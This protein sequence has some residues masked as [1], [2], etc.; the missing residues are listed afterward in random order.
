MNSAVKRMTRP[1]GLCLACILCSPLQAAPNF[2]YSQLHL[3]YGFAHFHKAL[4]VSHASGTDSYRHLKVWGI[5]GAYQLKNGVILGA[6]R[7]QGFHSSTL[8]QIQSRTDG[9]SV[10]Y[11]V[12]L[13]RRMDIYGNIGLYESFAKA[14]NQT[15]CVSNQDQTLG[16]DFG[17]RMGAGHWLEYGINLK[18]VPYP[19][20][21]ETTTFGAHTAILFDRYSSLALN[22]IYNDDSWAMTVGYRFSY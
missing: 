11:A 16:Y 4:E 2:G 6:S 19:K 7:T 9:L 21:G 15:D 14:C 17:L 18:T 13:K 8:T 12:G 1:V 22:G 20:F 3:Q 10:G 5:G